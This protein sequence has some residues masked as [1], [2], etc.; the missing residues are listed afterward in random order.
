MS[1]DVNV[2][3][4]RPLDLKWFWDDLTVGQ[5]IDGPGMTITDAHLVTWAGLTGDIVSLHLDD[6][7]AT[8]SR[9]GRRV[10]HG[11]L[12]MSLGLGLFT[13]TGIFTEV[14]AWLGVDGV[15]AL[16]PVHVGDTI[17]PRVTLEGSRLT[18]RGDRGVWTFAYTMLN[19]DEDVVMTFTSSLMI[20][21][22]DERGSTSD[23]HRLG[24]TH[25]GS[26]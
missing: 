25:D 1:A 16:A 21:R 10:A 2:V 4:V 15:R 23:G 13:Q 24:A 7:V 20:A 12:V 26:R 17:R 9:F 18:S 3:N 6:T 5:V 14:M 19:Q 11:P 8:R 22:R